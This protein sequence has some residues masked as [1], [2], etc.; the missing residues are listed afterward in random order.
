MTTVVPCRSRIARSRAPM[1]SSAS[2]QVAGAK[3]PVDVRRNGT[4]TRS[5]SST[6]FPKCTPFEQAKPRDAGWSESAAR[7]SSEQRA[8]NISRTVDPPQLGRLMLITTRA[9]ILDQLAHGDPGDDEAFASTLG[10]VRWLAV[11]QQ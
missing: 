6:T 9:S 3:S 4:V 5:R 2:S 8:G 11:R 10:H 1:S 7:I